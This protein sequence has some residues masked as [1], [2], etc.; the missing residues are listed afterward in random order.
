M[1]KAR[2]WQKGGIRRLGKGLGESVGAARGMSRLGGPVLLGQRGQMLS[3][4]ACAA[5]TGGGEG[6]EKGGGVKGGRR[7]EWGEREGTGEI[8]VPTPPLPNQPH[9]LNSEDILKQMRRKRC[10]PCLACESALPR[11]TREST[12]P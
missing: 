10:S 2:K 7:E 5:A 8:A 6:L 11:A 4:H 3:G 9:S 1:R 12:P